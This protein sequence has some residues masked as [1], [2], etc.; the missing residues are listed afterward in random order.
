MKSLQHK[1]SNTATR[2]VANRNRAAR[3]KGPVAMDAVQRME[4]DE[5]MQGKFAD[6]LQREGVED[7]ELMQ[8]KFADPL[9]REGVEDEELMQ[10][11]FTDPLQRE[12]V[13][14]EELMQ[15]KFT[16]S[17]Q[18]E[19]V[20][21]E[22]L[23]Q[24]KFADPLQRAEASEMEN[25]TGMPD[26]LKSG[27]EDLSG[28]DMSDVRVHYNSSKPQAVQAHA[29][30][31]GTDI[32]VAPG[33]EKHVPHES[34][35]VAQQKAGRVQPTTEVNGMAVNDDPGLEKEAD[36]KGAKAMQYKKK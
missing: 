30:A 3:G 4:D 1:K 6:P 23:M 8:G 22:E 7:E 31:Q 14:D 16:D 19:G 34:W 5:L 12:G 2:A 10:G 24:G 36:V 25:H 17:L 29:Y 28:M 18:R 15:G 33:Q 11:K 35:H 21:D 9:Q 20:E 27:V 13:E 32:Y 26:N